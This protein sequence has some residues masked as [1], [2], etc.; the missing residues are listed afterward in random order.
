[1]FGLC[2]LVT[3]T[4]G[5]MRFVS[6]CI[7][8]C[9]LTLANTWISDCVGN[10]TPVVELVTT[11]HTGHVRCV[12]GVTVF[13]SCV[14]SF[15]LRPLEHLAV[16][17][18]VTTETSCCRCF[19][20]DRDWGTDSCAV[21]HRHVSCVWN[22]RRTKL[23]GQVVKTHL[24]LW[25]HGSKSVCAAG[26]LLKPECLE[27]AHCVSLMQSSQLTLVLNTCTRCVGWMQ[28]VRI[29]TAVLYT[30]QTAVTKSGH[31]CSAPGVSVRRQRVPLR[32]A[33]TYSGRARVLAYNYV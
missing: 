18:A 10:Q 24:S 15:T 1:M 21:M 13:W 22:R 20:S 30:L 9:A 29:V 8:Q 32:G 14:V 11:W 12:D 7:W 17:D 19:Q 6:S 5:A 16:L 31:G 26:H 27:N 25:T 28:V 4:A 23:C 3:S 33:L 2:E